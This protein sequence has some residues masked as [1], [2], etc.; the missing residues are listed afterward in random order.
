MGGHGWGWLDICGVDLAEWTRVGCGTGVLE[1]PLVGV[2]DLGVCWLRLWA[3][4]GCLFVC[5]PPSVCTQQE[6]SG[7]RREVA[8]VW[9]GL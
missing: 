6:G 3:F 8:S 5:C 4:G 7:G 1:A 9:F 2:E